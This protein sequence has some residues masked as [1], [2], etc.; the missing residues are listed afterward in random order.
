MPGGCSD[1]ILQC[2]V[3]QAESDP[4]HAGTSSTVNDVCAVALEWC[5]DD[6]L[7]RFS[8]FTTRN[9]FD[10][11][12]I[13]VNPYPTNYPMTFLNQKMGPRRA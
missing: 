9:P 10:I 5:S 8:T 7:Q 6:V 2:R 13:G 11:S 4:G 1:Q 12:V 3:L